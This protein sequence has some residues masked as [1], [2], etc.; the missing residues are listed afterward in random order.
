MYS[1][2]GR[3][4]G[5]RKNAIMQ[6]HFGKK[7]SR[8]Q[9]IY[10]TTGSNFTN[11]EK[12]PVPNLHT[13][14]VQIFISYC[15]LQ[16]GKP[17]N[18]QVTK[19]VWLQNQLKILRAHDPHLLILPYDS[20]CKANGINH[21]DSFNHYINICV[22]LCMT[23]SLMMDVVSFPIGL[24]SVT[25]PNLALTVPLFLTAVILNRPL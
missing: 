2:G 7:K 22:L 4:M 23:H 5:I 16:R 9:E 11:L 6:G 21:P 14:P 1:H 17:R 13:E 19:R 3:G 12:G 20:S 10:A 24:V 15:E 18:A 25:L 8:E